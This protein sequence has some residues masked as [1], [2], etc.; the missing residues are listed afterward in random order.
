[1]ISLKEH[2][3]ITRVVQLMEGE[4]P[5][6]TDEQLQ[7]AEFYTLKWNPV[8]GNTK[9]CLFNA[10][11]EQLGDMEFSDPDVAIAFVEEF[12]DIDDDEA[13]DLESYAWANDNYDDRVQ[14]ALADDGTSDAA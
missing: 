11:S 3:E 1:M 4:S 7:A 8:S 13:A 2:I 9:L 14:N 12:F 5:Q 10:A 6:F